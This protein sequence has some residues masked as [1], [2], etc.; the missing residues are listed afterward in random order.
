[1]KQLVAKDKLHKV[2]LEDLIKI[3]L[4]FVLQKPGTA[5][6]KFKSFISSSSTLIDAIFKK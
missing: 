1:M 2:N 4:S 5:R 6:N 3:Y